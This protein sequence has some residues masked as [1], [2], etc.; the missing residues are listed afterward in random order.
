MERNKE[1]DLEM[2]EAAESGIESNGVVACIP[3][4]NVLKKSLNQQASHKISPVDSTHVIV[5]IV[6]V[7]FRRC[8]LLFL[9]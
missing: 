5:V 3:F 9:L 6:L 8:Q 7:V 1:R 2:G 4:Q